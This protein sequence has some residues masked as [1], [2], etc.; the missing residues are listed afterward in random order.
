MLHV[1]LFVVNYFVFSQS[2]NVSHNIGLVFASLFTLC[3]A[4]FMTTRM[5]KYCAMLYLQGL[6]YDHVELKVYINGR[7]TDARFTG[8]RGT[9]FPVMYGT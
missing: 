4:D 2:T 5:V 7:P 3:C 1:I 9:I 6:S 8:I